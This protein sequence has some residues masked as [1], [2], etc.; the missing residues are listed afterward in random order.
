[1]V[2][3]IG[4]VSIDTIGMAS[5]EIL[6]KTGSLMRQKKL[7]AEFSSLIYSVIDTYKQ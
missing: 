2:D 1:M 6:K 5:V 4:E 3:N 7:N